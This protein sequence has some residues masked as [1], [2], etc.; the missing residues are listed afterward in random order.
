LTYGKAVPVAAVTA[1]AVE[2]ALLLP[3]LHSSRPQM[4]IRMPVR[5]PTEIMSSDSSHHQQIR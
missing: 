5:V 1:V 2:S 3:K 4:K